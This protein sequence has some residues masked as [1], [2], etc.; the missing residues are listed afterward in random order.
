M[1]L[2][3]LKFAT[4]LCVSAS[5]TGCSGDADPVMATETAALPESV[6]TVQRD[7][8]VTDA[9]VTED[10]AQ[11]APGGGGG[12]A[13][14]PTTRVQAG[15]HSLPMS[16]LNCTNLPGPAPILKPMENHAM[17]VPARAAELP[18]APA[19]APAAAPEAAL[20]P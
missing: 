8:A 7:A 2:R 16:P 6:E 19:D 12:G 9:T 4:A 10:Q 17:P 15:P 3:F 14:C 1:A 20:L 18:V 5:L 13:P 11:P